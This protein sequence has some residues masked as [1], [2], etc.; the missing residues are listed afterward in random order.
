VSVIGN[1]VLDSSG[2]Y[3]GTHASGGGIAGDRGDV[4]IMNSTVANNLVRS[5][6]GGGSGGGLSLTSNGAVTIVNTTI[7]NNRAE[8]TTSDAIGGGLLVSGN[9]QPFQ[10]THATIAFNFAGFTGGGI[11]SQSNGTLLNTIVA[12][13]DSAGFTSPFQDQ[14]STQLTNGGGVLEF[15]ANNPACVGGSRIVADPRLGPLAA[16]GGF[17]PS[18]LLQAGSPGID[19]G[20]CAIATDQRGVA[21]PQGA[22]C[23]LGAVEVGAPPPPS[24]D[25]FT[26]NPCRVVDTRL[27]GPTGGAPLICG[28]E[29][30]LT[31]TGGAC[32]VPVSAKAVAANVTVTEPSK[33]GNLNAYPAFSFPPLTSVV[34]Y[35]AGS[36]RANNAVIPLNGAGQIAVRCAPTGTT[37]V[38]IDVGGYFQ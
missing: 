15:P 24:T 31:V 28:V 12:G 7:S 35:S 27:P 37:H 33:Q 6:A 21:R 19:A 23:D 14:C 2:T 10:V 5:T 34:N 4:T 3:L 18:H 22:A 38:V 11:T 17:S 36:T 1:Q 29:Q 16:N 30:V 20:A 26:L 25:F 8:G 13:N 9:T 32:G